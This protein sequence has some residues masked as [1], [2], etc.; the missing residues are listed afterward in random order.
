MLDYP[1]RCGRVNGETMGAP[2]QRHRVPVPAC[3]PAGWGG[4]RGWAC[5]GSG[6]G[7]G[8][9]RDIVSLAVLKETRVTM[10]EEGVVAGRAT[11]EGRDMRR[12]PM[13]VVIAGMISTSACAGTVAAFTDESSARKWSEWKAEKAVATLT[14]SQELGNKAPGALEITV[15]PDNPLNAGC[16]FVRHFAIRPGRTY[17]ALVYVRGNGIAPDSEISLGFQGQDE[18][19]HFLGTGVQS[20]RLKGEN[21]PTDG[22]KRIVL[23]FIIPETGKWEKAAILLCTLGISNAASGQVFFDDFEFLRAEE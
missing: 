1:Q 4:A 11:T 8:R 5:I 19:R 3:Y 20:A 15:G 9:C 16:C 12:W 6:A 22:W 17:T 14:H 13:G 7:R 10:Q 2:L 21:V 23:S 18:K